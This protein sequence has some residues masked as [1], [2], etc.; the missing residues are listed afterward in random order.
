MLYPLNLYPIDCSSAR[1]NL[2]FPQV[3]TTDKI[4]K[5]RLSLSKKVRKNRLST[6]R[7]NR[8]LHTDKGLAKQIIPNENNKNKNFNL[9]Q[10]RAFN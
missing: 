2:Y 7:Q 1:I 6:Y 4:N 5:P 10:S 3:N 8:N 9:D